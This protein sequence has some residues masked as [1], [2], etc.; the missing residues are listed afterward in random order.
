MGKGHWRQEKGE[1]ICSSEP[2]LNYLLL[3]G[4]HVKTWRH[5]I[6]KGAL[7]SKG[8]SFIRHLCRASFYRGPAPAGSRH[9]LRM[10]GIGERV[11]RLI[12][13]GLHRKPIKPLTRDLLCSRRSQ[14]PSRRSEDAERLLSGVKMQSAFSIGSWKPGQKSELREPLCSRE[15]A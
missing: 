9:T 13:L 7:L 14:A 8:H 10:N 15:S 6:V 4:T 2:H 11:K 5:M 12:V 1:V 3:Q